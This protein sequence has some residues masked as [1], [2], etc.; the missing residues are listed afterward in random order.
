[1]RFSLVCA[2]SRQRPNFNQVCRVPLSRSLVLEIR[3][4][5]RLAIPELRHSG[6]KLGF[7]YKI[8]R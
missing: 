2:W 4:G 8:Y 5:L 1:M 7:D 6:Q 3:L